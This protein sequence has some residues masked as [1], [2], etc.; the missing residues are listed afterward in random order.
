MGI[1]VSSFTSYSVVVV[2]VVAVAV[3]VVVQ[4]PEGKLTVSKL[5]AV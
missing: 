1:I 5:V 2:I 4:D 3:V